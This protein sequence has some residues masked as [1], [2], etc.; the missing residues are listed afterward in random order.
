MRWRDLTLQILERELFR[1]CA[2]I[3]LKLLESNTQYLW[4]AKCRTNRPPPPKEKEPDLL[5]S[6][7]FL[8]RKNIKRP[9]SCRVSEPILFRPRNKPKESMSEGQKGKENEA[10]YP[11]P[12]R[13]VSRLF[14]LR[15]TVPS[16]P[17]AGQGA[18][19]WLSG[20]PYAAPP[21]QSTARPCCEGAT[22][23]TVAAMF[24]RAPPCQKGWVGLL[25]F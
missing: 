12:P 8:A 1:G 4:I 2:G 14:W 11:T 25:R 13:L 17:L 3:T 10:K 6:S 18:H 23:T 22:A 5:R 19:Q 21:H 15:Y 24:R 9:K 20:D 16:L 7:R